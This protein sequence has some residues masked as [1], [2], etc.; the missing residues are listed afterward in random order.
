MY[1]TL[2]RPGTLQ[3]PAASVTLYSPQHPPHPFQHSC[4]PQ[5]NARPGKAASAGPPAAQGS[6]GSGGWME[7]K[8]GGWWKNK[9]AQKQTTHTAGPGVGC[10]WA[11]TWVACHLPPICTNMP[12][13]RVCQSPQYSATHNV[14]GWQVDQPLCGEESKDGGSGIAN[15]HWL[16]LCLLKLLDKRNEQHRRGGKERKCVRAHS[17]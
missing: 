7:G 8:E 13:S 16:V 15:D 17:C 12:A 2:L 5:T 1:S 9:R 10:V 11:G 6:P 4:R 3:A 14:E